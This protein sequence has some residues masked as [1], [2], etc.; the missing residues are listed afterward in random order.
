MKLKASKRDR[1][2]Y[3]QTTRAASAA[4]NG[5]RIVDAFIDRLLTQWFDEFTLD[6][7][8]ADAG[9]TVQTVIRRF[10]GKEGLLDE[11]AR[12]MGARINAKRGHPVG[13]ITEFVNN[14]YAD[15]EQTG[16][17]VMRLLALELRHPS[18]LQ[19]TNHGRREHRNWVTTCM[20]NFLA[21]L[22]AE[23]RQSVV[24]TLVIASDV[25]AWKLLRR[26]MK[27]SIPEAKSITAKMIEAIVLKK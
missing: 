11:A 6:Q 14:L 18:V 24:D 3:S 4:E 2:S 13:S 17:A 19:V 7:V 10:G 25:Y 9:V 5:Q 20:E 23:D 21:P 1:R 22:T 12:A 16:D 26:D 15:Y 27:R 8:A